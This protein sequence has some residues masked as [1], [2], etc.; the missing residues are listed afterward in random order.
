MSLNEN[1]TS[2]MI[3]VVIMCIFTWLLA[4][5]GDIQEPYRTAVLYLAPGCILV[6]W[7]SLCYISIHVKRQ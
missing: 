3:A 7:I 6:T 4:F 2:L 1:A 5:Y